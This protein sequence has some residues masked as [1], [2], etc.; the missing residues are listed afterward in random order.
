MSEV[1]KRQTQQNQPC[2][3]IIISVLCTSELKPYM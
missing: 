3:L 1:K 2:A